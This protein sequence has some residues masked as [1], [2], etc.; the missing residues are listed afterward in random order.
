MYAY[1]HFNWLN[2]FSVDMVRYGRSLIYLARHIYLYHAL[3]VSADSK[4]SEQ[5]GMW[6]INPSYEIY[7]LIYYLDLPNP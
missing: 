2:W 5:L 1:M 6:A 4:F 3:A 7:K